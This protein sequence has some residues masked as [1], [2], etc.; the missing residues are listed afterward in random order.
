MDPCSV[1]REVKPEA[2]VVTIR[3]IM[4]F[5]VKSVTGIKV[6]RIVMMVSAYPMLPAIILVLFP[7]TCS[8]M[9]LVTSFEMVLVTRPRTAVSSL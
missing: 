5:A 4:W 2:R 7:M 1:G 6:A 8:V 9:L 3:V